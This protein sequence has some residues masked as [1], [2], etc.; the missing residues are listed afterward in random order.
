MWP[1]PCYGGPQRCM[2][3]CR[4]VSFSKDSVTLPWRMGYRSLYPITR[5]FKEQG[6]P[7]R[8]QPKST[9][10]TAPYCLSLSR[11]GQNTRV[12]FHLHIT[13]RMLF[14]VYPA[15]Y[16]SRM[17]TPHGEQWGS[18]RNSTCLLPCLFASQ[19]ATRKAQMYMN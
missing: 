18:F 16:L 11:G 5:D 14:K 10:L 2:Q 8:A 12:L 6:A 4:R 1:L 17:R 3:P 19:A 9:H 15:T 7:S 13:G